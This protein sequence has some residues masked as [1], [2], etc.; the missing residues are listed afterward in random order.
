MTNF[1]GKLTPLLVIAAGLIFVLLTAASAGLFTSPDD[2][3]VLGDTHEQAAEELPQVLPMPERDEETADEDGTVPAPLVSKRPEADG[4]NG[5]ATAWR[6]GVTR[7]QLA[8]LVTERF[9]VTED[10]FLTM[11]GGWYDGV[12]TRADLARALVRLLDIEQLAA[13]HAPDEPI[14]RDVPQEHK[15]YGAVHMLQR[16]GIYPFHV[17]TLF[18]PDERVEQAEVVYTLD[19]AVQLESMTGPI[20]HMNEPARTVSVEGSPRQ[21]TAFTA[22]EQPFIVRNEEVVTF[23]ALRPG[24]DVHLIADDTGLLLVAVAT[25]PVEEPTVTTE[26]VA[27]LRE[28]A[29]PE[30]LAAIIARDWDKAA[31]ELRSSVYEQLV[32]RGVTS[33]EAAALL[34]RDW[35]MLEE[36]GK[37]RLTELVSG[38]TEINEELVRA[39][40]DQ[41]WDTALGHLEIEVLE[42]LLNKLAV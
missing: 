34:N 8:G 20:V 17:G 6:G 25:G 23:A 33:D 31:I 14:F 32:E 40:L 42:Y 9:D 11:T 16:L 5:S 22:G 36:R 4:P 35:P 13:E 15:A 38:N 7:G 21:A 30:Q 24:D 29:T 12:V 37:V 18:A 27:L 19:T 10:E 2:D 26:A 41:D 1:R 3:A 39:V 28:L